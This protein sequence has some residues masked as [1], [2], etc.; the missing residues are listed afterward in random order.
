M[1]Q[2]TATAKRTGT[3]CTRPAGIYPVCATHGQN[4]RTRIAAQRKYAIT[5]ATALVEKMDHE[6]M[7]D[8]A[9]QIL[10][11][12]Q[13]A[14][15]LLDILGDRVAELPSFS[16]TDKL[17]A[18]SVSAVLGAL[19]SQQ[20]ETGRLLIAIAKLGLE[21]R[22]VRASEENVQRMASALTA[23]LADIRL[24][25]THELQMEI[26]ALFSEKIHDV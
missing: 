25:L 14:R 20:R 15:D 11:L 16:T 24:G 2:C 1:A 5:E 19:Q 13:E 26:R 9:T 21:D 23:T 12:A 22:R 8:V 3:R 17:G 4:G 6:P 18:E 7:Q 10:I